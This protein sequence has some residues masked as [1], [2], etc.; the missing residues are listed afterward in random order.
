[1]KTMIKLMTQ[2]SRSAIVFRRRNPK[3]REMIPYSPV[4]HLK[5]R[6]TDESDKQTRFYPNCWYGA[7]H[8]CYNN[9]CDRK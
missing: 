5:S 1:M 3:L 2:L 6:H 9:P 4:G 7:E 8:P